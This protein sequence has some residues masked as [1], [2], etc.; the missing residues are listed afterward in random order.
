MDESFVARHPGSRPGRYVS[1]SIK[2]SGCGMDDDTQA[3]IFDPFFTTKSMGDGTGLG[4]TTVYG[5]IKQHHGYI[6]VSSAL[7]HGAQFQLYFPR[8]TEQTPNRQEIS[9]GTSV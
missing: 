5:I 4:L 8:V 7:G 9:N 3:H 6:T 1:L 2:D